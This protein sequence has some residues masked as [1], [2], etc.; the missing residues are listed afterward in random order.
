[1]CFE[2]VEDSGRLGHR[3][4]NGAGPKITRIAIRERENEEQRSE[5]KSGQVKGYGGEGMRKGK[6]QGFERG[7]S[8]V[9]P[10]NGLGVT[11]TS[12]AVCLLL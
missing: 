8:Q 3:L 10:E 4:G 9:S 11:Y 6:C 1:M 5:E 7:T 12:M 2:D